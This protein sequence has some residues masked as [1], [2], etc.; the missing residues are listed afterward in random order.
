M[1]FAVV[2]VLDYLV[3]RSALPSEI[4]AADDGPRVD[5]A[6]ELLE[7]IPK[8]WAALLDLTSSCE[9]FDGVADAAPLGSDCALCFSE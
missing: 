2:N 4:E 3:A 1:C 8:V 9:N 7:E 6:L 5:E